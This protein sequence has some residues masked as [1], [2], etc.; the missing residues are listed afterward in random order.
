MSIKNL[1]HIKLNHKERGFK[2]GADDRLQEA[3]H[4]NLHAAAKEALNRGDVEHHATI[5]EDIDA[6]DQLRKAD[7][8]NDPHDAVP[9]HPHGG[10]QKNDD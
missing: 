1:K 7:E 2:P 6:L 3:M 9:D 10:Y 4:K 8:I 5:K